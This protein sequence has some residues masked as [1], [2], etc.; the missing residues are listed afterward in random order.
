[1]LARLLLLA[2]ALL[3][4]GS[5]AQAQTFLSVNLSQNQVVGGSTVGGTVAVSAP[6]P[7]GGL[8]VSLW[9]GDEVRVPSSVTIPAG[10]T[11]TGFSV[12]TQPTSQPQYVRILA[13]TQNARQQ[14][15]LQVMPSAQAPRT[16]KSDSGLKMYKEYPTVGPVL[17]AGVPYYYPYGYGY[18][19]PYADP[20]AQPTHFDSDGYPMMH[21]EDGP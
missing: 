18:P 12:V 7:A 4:W 14:T 6:A 2:A 1:M 15:F 17:G 9:S 10:A 20:N 21:T 16:S 19:Y 3:A 11:Y 5:P 8:T 13:S